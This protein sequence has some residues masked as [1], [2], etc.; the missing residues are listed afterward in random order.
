M[1]SFKDYEPA[2]NQRFYSEKLARLEGHSSPY[3]E[4]EPPVC[5]AVNVVFLAHVIDDA[6][7]AGSAEDA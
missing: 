7:R 1:H 2:E 4:P 5:T 3:M 6:L